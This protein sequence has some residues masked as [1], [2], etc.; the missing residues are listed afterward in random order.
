MDGL[1]YTIEVDDS[2]A[3]A[4]TGR[5]NKALDSVSEKALTLSTSAS[6]AFQSMTSAIV[7]TGS[8]AVTSSGHFV[9][10]IENVFAL[11]SAYAYLSPHLIAYTANLGTVATTTDT[12]LN[13][14]R[15][16]RL[17]LSPTLFT[18]LT[19]GAG[20]AAE[21]IFKLTLAQ[22][23]L[24]QQRQALAASTD[25]SYASVERDQLINLV[26]GRTAAPGSILYGAAAQSVSAFNLGYT[27]DEQTKIVQLNRD[28]ETL[29]VTMGGLARNFRAGIEQLREF[30]AIGTA[31]TYDFLKGLASQLGAL[32]GKTGIFPGPGQHFTLGGPVSDDDPTILPLLNSAANAPNYQQALKDT[33]GPLADALSVSPCLTSPPARIDW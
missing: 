4:G 27:S 12:I 23:T 20:L 25:T 29:S 30:I 11:G 32:A 28:L 26:A 18:G 24:I 16:L 33:S 5:V 1:Q 8:A 6:A 22:G 31:N 2:P 10:L 21:S 13:S 14:F 9:R 15:L 17:A 3:V 19:I 7:A